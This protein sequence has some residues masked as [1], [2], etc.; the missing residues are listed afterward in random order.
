[1]V[2]A[3]TAQKQYVRLAATVNLMEIAAREGSEPIFELYR[4]QLATADLPLAIEVRVHYCT[5]LGYSAFGHLDSAMEQLEQARDLAARHSLNHLDAAAFQMRNPAL[6]GRSMADLAE[7]G[8]AFHD[9]RYSVAEFLFQ[10]V[11]G[12]V[13]VEL[14]GDCTLPRTVLFNDAGLTESGPRICW[15]HMGQRTVF[16]AISS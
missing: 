7:L 6:V 3:A 14:G 1:M 15:L 10:I 13:T 5:G 12:D 4:R 8:H 2:L 11:V 9:T 16:P